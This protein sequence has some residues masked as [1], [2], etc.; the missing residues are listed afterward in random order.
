MKSCSSNVKS[1]GQISLFPA[2][3]VSNGSVKIRISERS[4]AKVISHIV[5]LK[6]LSKIICC[7]KMTIPSLILLWHK[8]YCGFDF[9]K[10]LCLYI[11]AWVYFFGFLLIIFSPFFLLKLTT[12]FSYATLVSHFYFLATCI[13]LVGR[14]L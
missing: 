6:K 14:N 8:I 1:Y 9:V 13:V 3:W 5:D 11:S 2:Y 10:C 4:L 12:P 7:W